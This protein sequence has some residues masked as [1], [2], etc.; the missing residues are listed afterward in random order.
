MTA[1][2]RKALLV[3]TMGVCAL[4][5]AP[6]ASSLIA[7][8]PAHPFATAALAHGGDDDD[9]SSSGRGGND[10][11]DDND[12]RGGNR[13]SGGGHDNDDDDDDDD[14]GRHDRDDDDGDDQNDDRD[15]DDRDEMTLNVSEDSL[16][17]LRDGSLIAV[18]NLGRVLEVEVEFE[19]GQ[20][21]VKVEPHGGDARRNPG[22]ITSVSIV[23]ASAR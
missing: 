11:R 5:S 3:S 18:D 7:A 10:D 13:G 22:P 23:P 20:R 19:H 16:R 14:R 21:V 9:S 6:V 15:R 2:L 12:D 1:T 17:G 8:G 4:V